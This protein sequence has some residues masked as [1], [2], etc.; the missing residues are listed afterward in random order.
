M[1]KH[2][3][4]RLVEGV[5]RVG[6]HGSELCAKVRAVEKLEEW[7]RSLTKRNKKRGKGEKEKKRD[8]EQETSTSQSM[9]TRS[10]EKQEEKGSL[11]LLQ[12]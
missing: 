9:D 11:H 6:H 3:G 12:R 5:K 1:I 8:N 4:L 7:I 2:Q 10:K